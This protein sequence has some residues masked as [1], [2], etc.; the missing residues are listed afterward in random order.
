MNTPVD[1]DIEML[2]KI[3]NTI[4]GGNQSEF[5]RITHIKEST[6]KTW[7]DRK[8]VPDNKKL[9]LNTLLEN[10]ELKEK[11]ADYE[12]YFTLQGKLS[13]KFQN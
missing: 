11:L 13:K 9:L 7:R 8:K 6:I 5:A 2:D 3:I 12:Q 10:H 4:T 1:S